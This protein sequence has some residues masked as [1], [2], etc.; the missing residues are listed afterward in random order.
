MKRILFF[1][2]LLAFFA[3]CTSKST[4]ESENKTNTANVGNKMV[5]LTVE[6]MTCEGC[7][8]TVKE[9]VLTVPGVVNVA[10][11]FNDSAVKL[12][13]DSTVVNLEEVSKV[14]VDAGYVVK[15]I[16]K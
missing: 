15:G 4:P 7:E 14:I 6:G 8:N 5:L 2:L 13:V 12:D 10:A 11:S 3:A 1:A 9:A 16:K